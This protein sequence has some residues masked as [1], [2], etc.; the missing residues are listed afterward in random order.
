MKK[1][2]LE[3]ALDKFLDEHSA[4]LSKDPR[5]E[6]Y[7]GHRRSPV[8]KETAVTSDDDVVPKVKARAKKVAKAVEE[9][10]R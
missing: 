5:L 4:T 9:A 7:Y 2:D 8:K 3:S 6:G 10:V 1:A